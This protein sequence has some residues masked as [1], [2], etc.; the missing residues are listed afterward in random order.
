MRWKRAMSL[1][2]REYPRLGLERRRKIAGSI[3]GGSTKKKRRRR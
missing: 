3:V 2:R 1:A